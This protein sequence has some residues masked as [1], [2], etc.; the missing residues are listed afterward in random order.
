[1]PLPDVDQRL[2]LLTLMSAA[3]PLQEVELEDV[4][5][6]TDGYSGADLKALLQQAALESLVRRDGKS[7]ANE[8]ITRADVAPRCVTAE[9]A[10]IRQ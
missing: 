1:V 8:G 5:L 3:M 2:E 10:I 6:R 9:R 4:A 7:R